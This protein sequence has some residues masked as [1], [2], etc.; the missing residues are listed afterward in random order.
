MQTAHVKHTVGQQ[1]MCTRC[2]RMWDFDETPADDEVCDVVDAPTPE[3]ITSIQS[4]SYKTKR[5]YG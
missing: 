5:R 1:H 4:Q 2:K 3:I